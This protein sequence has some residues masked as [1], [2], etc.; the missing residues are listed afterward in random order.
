MIVQCLVCKKYKWG[1]G[2]WRIE[3]PNPTDHNISHTSCGVT[4]CNDEIERIFFEEEG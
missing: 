2:D 3:S 4:D 1:K